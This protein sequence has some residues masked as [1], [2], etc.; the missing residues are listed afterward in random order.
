MEALLTAKT[1]WGAS[2]LMASRDSA[3]SILRLG[4]ARM[5]KAREILSYIE[6]VL[7]FEV[8]D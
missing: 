6:T 7:S 3:E 4:Y 5:K 8:R 2:W 1:I